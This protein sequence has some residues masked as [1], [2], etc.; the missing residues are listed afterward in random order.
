M[1]VVELPHSPKWRV[2][3]LLEFNTADSKWK[4]TTIV[5]GL[6][7]TDPKKTT[8]T[9]AGVPPGRYQVLAIND[10]NTEYK[11]ASMAPFAFNV[12][13]TNSMTLKL[14]PPTVCVKGGVV[15]YDL[16]TG[17]ATCVPDGTPSLDNPECFLCEFNDDF[18]IE[19][20]ARISPVSG[21]TVEPTARAVAFA[22]DPDMLMYNLFNATGVLQ[23]AKAGKLPSWIDSNM[24]DWKLS[25]QVPA[26]KTETVALMQRIYS[27]AALTATGQFLDVED[28]IDA[29]NQ[30][31]GGKASQQ[32]IFANMVVA[33]GHRMVEQEK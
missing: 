13:S 17:F 7:N 15:A 33:L 29:A 30:A 19:K 11:H 6:D 21:M 28:P 26:K 14:R 20:V 10:G 16:S 32:T 27:R 3:R 23:P 18:T 1:L 4:L 12:E 22:C 8:V 31:L 25:Q 9:Y 2:E 24:F 5:A